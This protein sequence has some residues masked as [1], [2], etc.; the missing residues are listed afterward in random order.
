MEFGLSR[1][2][3]LVRGARSGPLPWKAVHIA[4]TN[5]K[6]TTSAYLAALLR[7]SSLK[8]GAFNSPH[9]IHRHDCITIDGKT[10]K[11]RLFREVNKAILKEDLRLGTKATAFELLTATAYEIFS[12]VHVDVAIVECG[13]GGRLD[14]TN[15]FEPDE[16]LCSIITKIGLDHQDVLGNTIEK[17][18][19]EKA[20]IIKQGVPLVFDASNKSTVKTILEERAERLGSH[21]T[22]VMPQPDARYWRSNAL[23]AERAYNIVKPR[24]AVAGDLEGTIRLSPSRRREVMEQAEKEFRGR[25]Q[26]VSI[27]SL[28]KR[29]SPIILDGAHNEQAAHALRI[30][31]DARRNIDQGL[32]LHSSTTWVLATSSTK[33]ARSILRALIR[34][35]DRVIVCE[36]GPVEGMPWV[37]P[38]PKEL[39]ADIASPYTD[40]LVQ[41]AKDAKEALSKAVQV[42]PEENQI[43]VAGSLYLVGDVLRL[44]PEPVDRPTWGGDDEDELVVNTYS[45]RR[46]KLDTES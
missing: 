21:Y 26:S 38:Q 14:A 2:T 18:A 37:K 6:G 10:V 29:A 4:G 8:V 24:L 17:I 39:L 25:F 19:G 40:H 33:D 44:G 31:V 12:R 43:V 46:V 22:L 7:A 35:G 41:T 30:A 15:I 9:L 34:H 27:K 28:T 45:M 23:L 20:G 1:I 13:L 36:F 5:G 32:L 16:L 3:K 11:K 42:T